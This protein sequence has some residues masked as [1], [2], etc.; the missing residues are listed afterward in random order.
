MIEQTLDITAKDGAM[1][2]FI[3]H[4]ERNGPSPAVFFLMDAY[5]VREEFGED[6]AGVSAGRDDL[7]GCARSCAGFLVAVG[8][9]CQPGQAELGAGGLQPRLATFGE[10]QSAARRRFGVGQV[11]AAFKQLSR[12]E[13]GCGCY[14]V[15]A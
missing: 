10:P 4:P 1:E 5:G 11:A 15:L 9:G 8:A 14:P 6:H 7:P 13:Q 12:C 2:T 3:C